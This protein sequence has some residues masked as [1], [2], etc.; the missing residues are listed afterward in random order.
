MLNRS[1]YP[2]ESCIFICPHHR[3][4][5]A[6]MPWS[7][8]ISTTNNSPAPT[9]QERVKMDDEPRHWISPSVH[10]YSNSRSTC[11]QSTPAPLTISTSALGSAHVLQPAA[12]VVAGAVGPA[13]ALTVGGVPSCLKYVCH[14]PQENFWTCAG[15]TYSETP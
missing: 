10:S 4:N 15:I 11:F 6:S 14:V 13:S 1:L 2:E 9:V 7:E 12:V 8:M 3:H 5:Q